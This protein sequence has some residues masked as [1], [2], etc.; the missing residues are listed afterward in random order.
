MKQERKIYDL[1]FKR[2]AVELSN[3]V[4]TKAEIITNQAKIT[5]TTIPF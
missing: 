3:E 2:K 5:K 1:E 4:Q